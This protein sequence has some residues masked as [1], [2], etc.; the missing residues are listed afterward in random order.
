MKIEGKAFS[1]ILVAELMT[2]MDDGDI[3]EDVSL[4]LTEKEVVEG[5]PVVRFE[6][7]TRIK[8]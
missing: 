6:L 4:S 3:F 2:R 7:N 8:P 1:N 5:Q